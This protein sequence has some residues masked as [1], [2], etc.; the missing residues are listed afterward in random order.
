M[1]I[2]QISVGE[3]GAYLS[4]AAQARLKMQL[5]VQLVDVREPEE[6]AIAEIF[7]FINLPLSQFSQWGHKI[8]ELLDQNTET[9]VLC[10]H[11]VRSM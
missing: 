1:T 8:H 7:G 10:H 6:L 11:G 4:G 3:L 2:S 9:L 5:P